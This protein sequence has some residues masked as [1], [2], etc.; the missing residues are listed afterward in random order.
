[1]ERLSEL[2]TE[3]CN[4]RTEHID[5]YETI[6][7]LRVMNQE[8]ETIAGAVREE[9]PHIADAVD[10]VTERLKEGGRLFYVGAGTSGRLGLLDAAECPPTFGTSPDLVQAYIAGGEDA[11]TQPSEGAEDDME[12]GVRLVSEHGIGEKDAIVGIAASGRTPYVLGALQAARQEGALT[13]GIAN[14]KNA[15]LKEFCD[16]CILPDVGP[17][18]IMGSTRLKSGTSQKMVLNMISTATMIKLGKVYKNLMVDMKPV[19]EKL[20]ARSRRMLNL[21]TG[22]SGKAAEEVLE[23]ADGELKTAIV[24][25]K[26][27]TD[28]QSARIMLDKNSGSVTKAIQSNR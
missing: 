17:E 11:I 3:V 23:A 19:N 20:V 7:I 26:T 24:M 9:L 13:I 14:N 4:K 28:P 8:D 2:E 25:L 6:D 12:A 1:M 27:K 21:A 22:V 16:I 15:Q 18:V 5:E 10:G